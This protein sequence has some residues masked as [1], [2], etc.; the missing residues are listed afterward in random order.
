MPQA[1]QGCMI[2]PEGPPLELLNFLALFLRFALPS[3]TRP[4][5]SHQP[6]SCFC[7]VCSEKLS[8]AEAHSKAPSLH[9]RVGLFALLQVPFCTAQGRGTGIA[10]LHRSGGWFSS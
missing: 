10:V 6:E 5:A 9:A 3:G 2:A 8:A 7:A 4:S 1:S